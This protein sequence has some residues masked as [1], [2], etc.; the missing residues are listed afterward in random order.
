MLVCQVK[1]HC[2]HMM[3]TEDSTGMVAVPEKFAVRMKTDKDYL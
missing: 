3:V 2:L 1:Q